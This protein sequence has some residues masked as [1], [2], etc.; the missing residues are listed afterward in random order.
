MFVFVDGPGLARGAAG[1]VAIALSSSVVTLLTGRVAGISGIVGPLVSGRAPDLF[2]L[3]YT[4]GLLCAGAVLLAV[5][6]RTAIF[7]AADGPALHWGA[8]VVGGLAI[9]FG[10]RLGSGCTSGHGI[11]GLA[12]LSPRSL[13]AVA[14]FF[15]VAIITAGVSRSSALRPTLYGAEAALPSPTGSFSWAL[16]PDLYIVPLVVAVAAGIL[17]FGVVAT[18]RRRGRAVPTATSTG[19]PLPES[20]YAAPPP[21]SPM[22]PNAALLSEDNAEGAA[23]A[24][25]APLSAKVV[26]AAGVWVSG[27]AFGLALGM[28]GMLNPSKVLR[29]LDFLGDGGWDPQLILVMGCGVAANAVLVRAMAVGAFATTVPPLAA[30]L[31]GAQKPLGGI[32]NYGPACAANRKIDAALIGGSVLF[33]FGWGLTG[34]C[35]GPAVV[36]YVTG[37]AH[38]GVV[39]P[40]LLFG[41]AAYEAA[42]LK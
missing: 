27:F 20:S 6:P 24:A 33:G 29:F 7:G 30:A 37:G 12:R 23:A 38:Y 13:A 40:A 32:I 5:S 36:D 26:A 22:T 28:S 2:S 35:P 3:A 14:A 21:Q 11:I 17:L 8:C 10:T 39:V 4:A 18:V 15:S 1:G 19:T 25:A 34:V 42:V 31:G 9:G 16:T 41:M